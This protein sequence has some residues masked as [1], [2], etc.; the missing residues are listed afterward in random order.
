MCRS[1]ARR[2]RLLTGPAAVPLE[3]AQED[4]GHRTSR[5]TLNQTGG[6]PMGRTRPER[7][8]PRRLSL[9]CLA[10]ALARFAS[11]FV[12]SHLLPALS[13]PL[14][15]PDTSLV[16]HCPARLPA[17]SASCLPHA[18]P[19]KAIPWP[20]HGLHGHSAI[21]V[22]CG[23]CRQP[24]PASQ[25]SPELGLPDP[26]LSYRSHKTGLPTPA[27]MHLILGSRRST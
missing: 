20:L 26:A 19:C 24:V 4:A 14:L 6:T 21:P 5:C 8:T 12:V 1:T 9:T 2:S 10:S 15:S 17:L 13:L 22:A 16:G 27:Q 11:V 3:D 7:P 25:F 23:G 18:F